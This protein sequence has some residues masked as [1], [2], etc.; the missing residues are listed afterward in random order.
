MLAYYLIVC[1]LI[2]VSAT[3]ILGIWFPPEG[4]ILLEERKEKGAFDIIILLPR[5]SA[6]S[7]KSNTIRGREAK[8]APRPKYTLI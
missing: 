7:I 3:T 8:T 2:A 5:C 6:R 1:Y 4:H